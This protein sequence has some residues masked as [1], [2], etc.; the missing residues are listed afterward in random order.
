MI[1]VFSFL[2]FVCTLLV[3]CGDARGQ[4]GG[5]FVSVPG[6]G[7]PGV[8]GPVRCCVEWDPDGDGPMQSWLVVGGY[9]NAAGDVV[10]RCVAGWDGTAWR[11][12]GDVL[13]SNQ[14]LGVWDL[15]VYRGDLYATNLDFSVLRRWNGST[16]VLVAQGVGSG[17]LCEYGGELFWLGNSGAVACNG[18]ST[19]SIASGW[20]GFNDSL[21]GVASCNGGVFA[22]WQG[23][24]QRWN[25]AS[26]VN[27]TPPGDFSGYDLVSYNGEPFVRGFW[28]PTSSS[29]HAARW[30]SRGW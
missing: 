24:V 18:V 5:R 26:W 2:A 30:S 10:T 7:V 6:R 25:G 8:D 20:Q 17:R 1:R 16:W 3:T 27:V 11:S 12:F 28:R 21:V 15:A 29:T 22:L 23:H 19:R 14:Q 13:L 9:F 4:C